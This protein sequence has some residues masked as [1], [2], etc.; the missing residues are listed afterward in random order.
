MSSTTELRGQR[1]A[2]DCSG[3]RP[4]APRGTQ[5]F[6]AAKA[7]P[8]GLPEGLTIAQ[9]IE[10]IVASCLR[11]LEHN[12]SLF[13]DRRDPE[14]LHQARV[15][16]RRLRS[17]LAMFAPLAGSRK[18]TRIKRELRWL[19]SELGDA[20][21]LDVYLERNLSRDQ[22]AFGEERRQDAYDRAAA[23]I[24]SS[25]SR[26]LLLDLLG[27]MRKGSWRFNSNAGKRLDPFVG[28]QID[29]L[30][31]RISDSGR[32]ARMNDRRLHRLRIRV[33]KLR[34]ALEFTDGLYSPR[35][36]RK[37][38]FGKALKEAQHSLGSLHDIA[39]A[40]SMMALNPWLATD[41]P[42]AKHRKRLTRDADR[43]LARLR[44]AGPYW[45]GKRHS[46]A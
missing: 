17:A 21:N 43:A 35:E 11:H 24:A 41:Q 2:L 29:R 13:V 9:G 18:L 19:V 7:E 46:H 27:W 42:S 32:V 28:R 31:T 34:Y 30:W 3:Q 40:G 26:L 20:R 25:R 1:D 16:I 4:S 22:R 39:A 15:A 37:R 14:A 38:K 36:R 5:I 23:A 33:K 12:Q 45:H 44:R 8:I 10:A 6:E